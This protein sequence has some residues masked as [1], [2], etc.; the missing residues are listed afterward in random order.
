M[1]RHVHGVSRRGRDFRVR[2][3]RGKRKNRMVRIIEC[4]NDEVRRAGVIRVFLKHLYA[5]RSGQRLAAKSRVP[6]A[7]RARQESA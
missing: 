3:R 1:R 7:N 5:D 2:A 6:G 4:M